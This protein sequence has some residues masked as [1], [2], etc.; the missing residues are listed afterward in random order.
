MT[1]FIPQITTTVKVEANTQN[2]DTALDLMQSDEISSFVFSDIINRIEYI[3]SNIDNDIDEVAF[4]VSES[5]SSHQEQI[6]SMKHNFTGMMMSSVDISKDGN[7]QYLVG[8]TATSVDGF[9]Y[10]LAIETGRREVFPVNAK[11]L[12]WWT[13]AWFS[14]DMVF[15]KKSKAVPADPFVQPSIDLTLDEVN[16]IVENY[17]AK[18]NKL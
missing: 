10:P 8:N 16:N 3:K 1:G 14:G 2:L 4:A 15:A 12:R 11:M 5:L 17:V 18:I 7:A 9:P 6:I 13:G